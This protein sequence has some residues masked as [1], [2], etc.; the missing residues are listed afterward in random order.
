MDS[1]RSCGV[2]GP[3]SHVGG[4]KGRDLN[5]AG[6]VAG[7]RSTA[8]L[9]SGSAPF[10]PSPYTGGGKAPQDVGSYGDEAGRLSWRHKASGV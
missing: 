1:L 10:H 8:R 2:G 9:H 7:G 3:L 5:R 6:A 4:M